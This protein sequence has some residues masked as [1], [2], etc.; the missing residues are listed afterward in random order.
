MGAGPVPEVLHKILNV[1]AKIRARIGLPSLAPLSGLFYSVLNLMKFGEHRGGMY[2]KAQGLRHGKETAQSW[3]LLAEGDDGPYIPSVAIEAII[4]KL[5]TG[6]QP[7]FGA[8]PATNA[9][10]IADYV[11]LFEN[12]SIYSGFR[13]QLPATAPLYRQVLG[14]AFDTLPKQVQHLHNSVATRKWVGQA[15]VRRGRGLLSKLIGAIIG[16]PKTAD[17]VPVSV[18]LSPE[19]G[20]ERWTRNFGGKEFS[21]LQKLGTGK[22]NYL[23]T[24]RFGMVVVALDLVIKKD[25]LYL[26]PRRWSLLGI[27]LPTALLPGGQS[28]ETQRSGRF[29]FDVEITVPLIGLIAAYQGELEPG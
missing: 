5:L 21:S 11:T 14:D 24:E 12:R 9:L 25:R 16:F 6:K 27:P 17:M 1:L 7:G 10:E 3:H 29:N 13:Q 4:R 22:N 26:V 23:I 8:R 18:V 15:K 28:F 19:N 20:G 2:V